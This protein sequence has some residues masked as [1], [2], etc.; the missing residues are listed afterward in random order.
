MAKEGTALPTAETARQEVMLPTAKDSADTRTDKRAEIDVAASA[1]S[2]REFE[3]LYAE[4]KRTRRNLENVQRRMRL[5]DKDRMHVGRLLRGEITA[6]YLP[7]DS[8]KEGIIAVYEAKQEYENYAKRIREWNERRKEGLGIKAQEYLSG[9]QNW[10]DKTRFGGL[11]YSVETMERN[12]RDIMGEDAEAL[13]AE[14]ITPVHKAEYSKYINISRIK[15]PFRTDTK[16]WMGFIKT[17]EKLF[18]GENDMAVHKVDISGVNTAKLPVLS[19][20]EK[21]ELLRKIREGDTKARETFTCGNLRL[22]LSVIQRFQS[23]GEHL[24]D[25]FQVGC[26]GLMKAIDN[27]DL[28]HGVKFS[29]YAVPMNVPG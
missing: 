3:G 14:Y 25:L 26:I 6:E 9:I 7:E 5:S 28:G 27:F 10:K 18:E 12:F 1:L 24:D 21:E 2:Q 20:T 17:P 13:I 29:T 23:R 15:D 16:S 22:V 19:E 11:R 4:V 8:D